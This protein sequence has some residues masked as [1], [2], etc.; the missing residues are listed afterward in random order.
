[1]AN[2]PEKAPEASSLADQEHIFAQD[3][4]IL[5]AVRPY[6]HFFQPT[7]GNIEFSRE[8]VEELVFKLIN[9]RAVILGGID[10]S[11]NEKNLLA[12]YI[13]C[14]FRAG[15]KEQPEVW[16]WV[17]SGEMLDIHS[18]LLEFEKRILVFPDLKPADL[19]Y[20]AETILDQAILSE[21]YLII[22][23]EIDLRIFEGG[24]IHRQWFEDDSRNA[25]FYELERPQ[26]Y[27]A[28]GLAENLR[29]LMC[30]EIDFL[31]TEI[32]E[33][34]REICDRQ[35]KG[36]SSLRNIFEPLIGNYSVK[37][38]AEFF[39]DYDELAY[40][41][42]LLKASDTYP[43]NAD[44][45]IGLVTRTKTS[46][47]QWVRWLHHELGYKEKQILAGLALLNGLFEDQFFVALDELV[48]H[49]W[50]EREPNLNWFDYAELNTLRNVAAEFHESGMAYRKIAIK[51]ERRRLIFDEC[52]KIQER[53]LRAGV[54][55]LLNLLKDTGHKDPQYSLQGSNWEMLQ[56]SR[57]PKWVIKRLESIKEAVFDSKENY[58]REV[59]KLIG[60]LQ[61]ARSRED[62]L[63]YA[64]P[65]KG[66]SEYYAQTVTNNIDR[67]NQLYGT[68][69]RKIL[70]RNAAADALR[71]LAYRTPNLAER[72]LF[73]LAGEDAHGLREVAA[74]SL[75]KWI[76]YPS[77]TSRADVDGIDD[78]K[79]NELAFYNMLGRWKSKPASVF[80]ANGSLLTNENA[81]WI[82]RH[83]ENIESTIVIALGYAAK[84]YKPGTLPKALLDLIGKLFPP[85]GPRIKQA[86]IE[87]TIPMLIKYHLWELHDKKLLYE[88]M[89]DR[90]CAEVVAVEMAMA[91][92]ASPDDFIDV[93]LNIGAKCWQL[94]VKKFTKRGREFARLF[95]KGLVP[96]YQVWQ[97]K[98]K[99]N[100]PNKHNPYPSYERLRSVEIA[101]Y[102]ALRLPTNPAGVNPR[103]VFAFLS[104]RYRDVLDMKPDLRDCTADAMSQLLHRNFTAVAQHLFAFLKKERFRKVV[105]YARWTADHSRALA[106]AI[107]EMLEYSRAELESDLE[108]Q[109][110]DAIKKEASD[111]ELAKFDPAKNETEIEATMFKWVRHW[112]PMRRHTWAN[113]I[114]FESL[115]LFFGKRV[116]KP[117]NKEQI[118]GA[119]DKKLEYK[120]LYWALPV[121]WLAALPFLG[122]GKLGLNIMR[123]IPNFVIMWRLRSHIG[124]LAQKDLDIRQTMKLWAKHAKD[125]RVKSLSKALAYAY[126]LAD[127]V[128]IV[129]PLSW[130]VAIVSAVWFVSFVVAHGGL[131]ATVAL[132]WAQLPDAQFF[133]GLLSAIWDWMVGALKAF[134]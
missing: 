36:Q 79:E 69:H 115:L 60:P 58:L 70:I 49:E 51:R 100:K 40:F 114:A 47:V 9:H 125:K 133:I 7:P 75:A 118:D 126:W 111:A 18:I 109:K 45:L 71:I 107:C 112:L 104:R 37:A 22:T 66:T 78:R 130:I 14:E 46:K 124:R 116:E 34:L 85:K 90:D 48:S 108:K 3:A 19:L 97:D 62:L 73:L 122:P 113:H 32:A 63:S 93:M 23:T 2:I 10:S 61:L 76:E 50:R 33:P 88:F 30:A 86:F 54:D 92:H 101:T 121:P 80:T 84:R 31:P 1:M 119:L 72:K 44:A 127:R 117:L 64:R 24:V 6:P 83:K 68:F 27:A 105:W 120:Y 106:L 20:K 77:L 28:N 21:N 96:F 98:K 42:D 103:S 95:P 74:A 39:N 4:T 25:L 29:N 102:G 56:V 38:I 15:L 8:L 89:Q 52:W 87:H 110:K 43:F 5:E 91:Y 99:R 53:L 67:Q 131:F 123:I 26:L 132:F 57:V 81:L 13:A 82:S 59:R 35:S 129:G 94:Q 128:V 12:R 16:E 65:I 41:V 11:L 134:F 17:R 55:G